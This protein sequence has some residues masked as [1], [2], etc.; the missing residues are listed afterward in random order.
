MEE[1]PLPTIHVMPREFRAA[2]PVARVSR[3]TWIIV[4]I[5]GVCV[6]ALGGA[7]WYVMASLAP[8]PAAVPVATEAPVALEPQAP[9]VPVSPVAPEEPSAPDIPVIS[10][11]PTALPHE[12]T[13]N[14]GLTNA[15]EG[16]LSTQPTN[17]DT[18][19]DG[20][21]D[22]HEVLNLYNPGGF[23]PER[24]L[25]AGLVREYDNAPQRISFYY[26][27]P[28]GVASA[29]DTGTTVTATSLTGE[30]ITL[31]I[32]PNEERQPLDAWYTTANPAGNLAT[33]AIQTKRGVPGI[34]TADAR[35]AF[36][37]HGSSVV[38]I[39]YNTPGEGPL[40]YARV[41]EMMVAS[42]VFSR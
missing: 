13:D 5:V 33:S 39:R 9:P 8:S 14:D 34:M 12:D 35:A 24:L 21:L 1:R 22:G 42:L 38:A 31:T 23:Q 26:P 3:R 20:F 15:E 41:F 11:T 30:T 28:W 19:N 27:A 2:M 10:P 18:D 40:L 17:P 16:V 29:D 37:A 6:L 25:D 36:F 32:I 7:T 4:G